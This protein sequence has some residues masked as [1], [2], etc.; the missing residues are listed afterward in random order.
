MATIGKASALF[1]S[2]IACPEEVSGCISM[3]SCV[4][5]FKPWIVVGVRF[6]GSA[7]ALLH[8]HSTTAAADPVSGTMKGILTG[9]LF[10]FRRSL[11]PRSNSSVSQRTVPLVRKLYFFYRDAARPVSNRHRG[12]TQRNPKWIIP[13]RGTPESVQGQCVDGRVSVYSALVNIFT[14]NSSWII[15]S[16]AK[17]KAAM[18]VTRLELAA[19]KDSTRQ[20]EQEQP[21]EPGQGPDQRLERS[22]GTSTGGATASSTGAVGGTS[23]AG[24]VVV[25]SS[26]GVGSMGAMSASGSTASGTNSSTSSSG[27]TGGQ[28]QPQ[29]QHGRRRRRAARAA[30]APRLGHRLGHR[31]RHEGHGA[32]VGA[33][34]Q[35]LHRR[36]TRPPTPPSR[37]STRPSHLSPQQRAAGGRPPGHRPPT[38]AWTA[39]R[40][41]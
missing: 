36:S 29:R 23:N 16:R 27:S 13:M 32:Q 6:G 5:C 19:R 21:A 20:P 25:E 12:P 28:P 35:D 38:P 34:A 7:S 26:Q 2:G 33:K 14:R 37:W 3:V 30:W 40:A 11:S 1:E 4:E 31:R 17:Q 10:A 8:L 18:S 39:C 22:T 41:C 24:S 15:R 9:C